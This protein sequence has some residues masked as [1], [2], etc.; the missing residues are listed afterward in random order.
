MR[1]LRVRP[2]EMNHTREDGGDRELRNRVRT[3]RRV[4]GRESP[5]VYLEGTIWRKKLEGDDGD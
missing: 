2:A 1:T 3:V 4:G 5:V